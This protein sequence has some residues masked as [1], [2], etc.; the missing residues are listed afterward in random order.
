MQIWDLE[1]AK[2]FQFL[3]PNYARGAHGILFLYS[4][5]NEESLY[6]FDDFMWKIRRHRREDIPILLVGTKL[7]LEDER[8][9]TT[10]NGAEFAKSRS[11]AGFIEVSAKDNIN[12]KKP[13]E[14]IAQIMWNNIFKTSLS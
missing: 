9:V 1:T 3:L 6:H 10:E 13:F 12:V 7:D 8:K 14:D 4:I 11:C 2:E 5:T